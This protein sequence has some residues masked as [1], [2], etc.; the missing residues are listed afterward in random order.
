MNASP[1]FDDG[2]PFVPVDP[3]HGKTRSSPPDAA[4][5]HS[6]S[7]GRNP[8]SQMQN[9]YA[10]YHVTQL[11]AFCSFVPIDGVHVADASH[12]SAVSQALVLPGQPASQPGS[13]PPFT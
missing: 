5:S 11:I 4:S 2:S 10:S 3:D 8:P 1:E 6:A 7:V 13:V 12:A 9:A